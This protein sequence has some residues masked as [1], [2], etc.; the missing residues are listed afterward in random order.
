MAP[1]ISV[2]IVNFN[3]FQLT[4]ECVRSIRAKTVG[5]TYE[6]IVV[7]NASS[8]SKTE[9]LPQ[10]LPDIIY[11]R[12]ETNLGFAKANNVGLKIAK[13]KYILLLNSDTELSDNALLTA[14]Q[15]LEENS[16][17]GVTTVRLVYPDG[18][19]QHNCHRFPSVR[20]KAFEFFRLQK[21]F[22]KEGG[23]S[24]LGSFFSY[25]QVIHPD[26]V[27]GTF[28]MFPR[29]IVDQL[30]GGKLND[31]YFLYVEDMEWCKEIRELGYEITFL[32]TATIIHFLGKS[33][34]DRNQHMTEN[35]KRFMRKHYSASQRVA[36]S[37]F[38]KLLKI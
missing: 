4:C 3:T 30:P 37:L 32:P 29:K 22:P 12:N 26:W 36:I 10:V 33:G 24:L 38:D 27:W 25:D 31:D 16:A 14:K 28:F 5:C 18:R 34:A 1:E 2:I 6:I 15:Y 17:V 35:M 19:V 7:D 13:G 21:L 8:E 20:Y 11:V 9:A 23:R